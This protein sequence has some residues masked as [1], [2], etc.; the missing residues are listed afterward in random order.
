MLTVLAHMG[1]PL[2]PHDLWGAW[3]PDPLLLV[4][5]AVVGW[6]Y[7]RGREPA[8]RAR[9]W[10][11]AGAL[12]ALT[13]ALV[14]PL[15]ALAGAL[16]SAH[17][18]Q[19]VLLVLV[20]APLLAYAAPSSAVLRGAPAALRRG[21]VRLRDI[22]GVRGLEVWRDPVVV[23]LAHVAVLWLWHAAVLYD[24]ALG[25]AWV[26]ALEHA[27][28]LVTAVLLWR[29]VVSAR[30]GVAVSQ[31]AGILIVFGTAMQSVFLSVLMVFASS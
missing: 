31:G 16:A 1:R 2:E 10:A 14:S 4:G 26:H 5:L 8:G 21:A 27:T 22:L 3:N 24:A 25:S 6:A 30:R 19:H 28:F 17:M 18:V 9:G 23:W 13:V 20:A 15:D 12:A 7:A 29:V 11:F